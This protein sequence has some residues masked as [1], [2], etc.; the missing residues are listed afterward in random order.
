MGWFWHSIWNLTWLLS[1]NFVTLLRRFRTRLQNHFH[2]RV[3]FLGFMSCTRKFFLLSSSED[4]CLTTI[5]LLKVCGI[6][7]W[8]ISLLF[9]I[10]SNISNIGRSSLLLPCYPVWTLIFMV[11]KNQLLASKTLRTIANAYSQLLRSSLG[12]GSI[13]TPLESFALISN[14]GHC[15]DS[16]NNC[17]KRAFCGSFH[18]GGHNGGHDDIKVRLLWWY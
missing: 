10:Y 5:A 17:G 12:Q 3:M 4:H 8:R 14:S 15:S 16:S 1:L 6:N 11:L 2:N 18:G 9:L 7:Y 13:L